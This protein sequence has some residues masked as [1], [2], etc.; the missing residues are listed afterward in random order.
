MKLSC[1]K[2]KRTYIHLE[3][4][5]RCSSVTVR[6]GYSVTINDGNNMKT[7]ESS[8]DDMNK[9]CPNCGSELSTDQSSK[10]ILIEPHKLVILFGAGASKGSQSNNPPPLGGELLK[11][12]LR[13][14]PKVWGLI[15]EK[16]LSSLCLDFETG[17]SEIGDSHGELLPKLLRSMARYFYQ[18]TPSDDSLYLK[19]AT[20]IKSSGKSIGL[21]TLNYDRL[22]DLSLAKTNIDIDIC[23]PHGS[24]NLFC[25]GASTENDDASFSGFGVSTNG[26][27]Y[28]IDDDKVFLQKIKSDSFPPVMSYFEYEKRATSGVD[29]IEEQKT[30]WGWLCSNAEKIL[31]IGIKQ[32]DHDGHIWK[33]LE[34][35]QAKIMFCGG[36]ESCEGYQIWMDKHGRSDEVLR[37]YFAEEFKNLCSFLDI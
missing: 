26:H 34:N 15:P 22:L 4:D 23:Y 25:D 9:R 16:L 30:K 18:F 7:M 24:C 2:C 6:S 29:F 21:A 31:V 5:R 33:P 12:L 27:I 3:N 11:E 1:S 28:S 13:Q 20:H 35:T 14:D 36:P 32:R 37:G 17:M 8:I 19:L 10:E